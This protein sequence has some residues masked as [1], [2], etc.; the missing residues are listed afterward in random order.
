MRLNG[1][2]G[3]IAKLAVG[4]LL[5]AFLLWRV[6]RAELM[7]VLASAS[8]GLL[9]GAVA[10]SLL[11]LVVVQIARFHYLLPTGDRHLASSVRVL[12]VALF[13]N[14]LL[15]TS[16]GGDA[17]KALYLQRER[18]RSWSQALGLV[19][20]ERAVASLSLIVLGGIAVVAATALGEPPRALEL[21]G[22]NRLVLVAALA[23]GLALL[24][25]HRLL[26]H[27]AIIRAIEQFVRGMLWTFATAARDNWAPIA[28]W[29]I[30]FHLLRVAGLC[31]LA[32]A[33]AAPVP[34]GDMLLIWL[35]VSLVSMIPIT[36]GGLGT[37][38]AAFVLAL[39]FHG[40]PTAAAV[41]VALLNR[42]ILLL[43]GLLG[44]A[45]WIVGRRSTAY[46]A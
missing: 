32:A 5:M 23:G 18:G 16:I 33:F 3:V 30:L 20:F 9:L 7:A 40:M 10:V 1:A 11:A 34:F 12:L 29:S 14:N 46:A 24:V 42:A 21:M 39:A 28:S 13:L 43:C 2:A 6:D 31:L 44:L 22:A 45:A 15:P 41:A 4:G 35:L 17:V 38:E 26:R 27:L 8:R 36:V 37:V 19:G 25:L